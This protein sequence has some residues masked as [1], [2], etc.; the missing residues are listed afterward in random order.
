MSINNIVTE[1]KDRYDLILKMIFFSDFS[2]EKMALES[3]KDVVNDV[4]EG[5]IEYNQACVNLVHKL[6][7]SLRLDGMHIGID[8]IDEKMPENEAIKCVKF[9]VQK[10]MFSKFSDLFLL[11][12]AGPYSSTPSPKTFIE[13]Y[14]EIFIDSKDCKAEEEFEALENISRKLSSRFAKGLDIDPNIL[15]LLFPSDFGF[16]EGKFCIIYAWAIITPMDIVN[17]TALHYR[18]FLSFQNIHPQEISSEPRKIRIETFI[19]PVD[20]SFM[21]SSFPDKFYEY[22]AKLAKTSKPSTGGKK[23][24]SKK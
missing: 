11:K 21:F 24:K 3:C 12:T 16:F 22:L 4:K 2:S 18:T 6:M 14:R 23:S 15:F 10:T 19:L 13:A 20:E 7:L 9:A 17:L 1:T 5:I 8:P